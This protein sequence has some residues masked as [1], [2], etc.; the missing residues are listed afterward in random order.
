MYAQQTHITLL[1]YYVQLLLLTLETYTCTPGLH[2]RVPFK[3]NGVYIELSQDMR[4]RKRALL[5]R[6]VP[7]KKHVMFYAYLRACNSRVHLMPSEVEYDISYHTDAE[8]VSLIE[9][10]GNF[11]RLVHFLH[12]LFA[13]CVCQIRHSKCHK[14]KPNDVYPGLWETALCSREPA[15][16][17]LPPILSCQPKVILLLVFVLN[18]VS[19]FY[20]FILS[21]CTHMPDSVFSSHMPKFLSLAV[22]S[23]R[24]H[25]WN[26]LQF[27]MPDFFFPVPI[28]EHTNCPTVL[29]IQ[30]SDALIKHSDFEE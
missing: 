14:A 9:S 1:L 12:G 29:W 7:H 30:I 3:S 10:E 19:G 6:D 4:E 16:G 28:G 22:F 24:I 26:P 11:C 8:F 23:T 21:F 20:F 18:T 25:L 17:I 5:S 27:L 2:S 13:V 15:F